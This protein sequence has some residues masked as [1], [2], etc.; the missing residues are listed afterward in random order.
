MKPVGASRRLDFIGRDTTARIASQCIVV[1]V[2]VL[3]CRS[4]PR[5]L[6]LHGAPC[7]AERAMRWVWPW[8]GVY[9]EAHRL[10]VGVF[11][12]PCNREVDPNWWV[13]RLRHIAMSRS[14]QGPL[15]FN[16][17]FPLTS[18]LVEEPPRAALG[19]V[20]N[21]GSSLRVVLQT[22]RAESVMLPPFAGLGSLASAALAPRGLRSPDSVDSGA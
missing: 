1:G 22:G 8:A 14:G 10:H 16:N 4:A 19:A 6:C 12:G 15:P 18:A 5:Q 9:T 11:F 2:A 17:P 20:F 21:L 7:V 13:N 3:G